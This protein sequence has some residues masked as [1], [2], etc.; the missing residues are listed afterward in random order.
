MSSMSIIP[1]C[2]QDQVETLSN[3]IISHGRVCVL[4][5]YLFVCF[6]CLYACVCLGT[7][8]YMYMIN[9]ISM[10]LKKYK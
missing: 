4:C 1:S 9:L 5:F 6:V 2:H 8:V 10:Y 3:L 7:R